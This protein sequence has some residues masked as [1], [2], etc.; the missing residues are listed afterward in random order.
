MKVLFLCGFFEKNIE[1]LILQYAKTN[2]DFA[3][4]NFQK[5]IIQGLKGGNVNYQV[6]SAPFIGSYPNASKKMFFKINRKKSFLDQTTECTYVNFN[7]VWGIRNFSRAK[8]L[9]RELKNFI[10][11]K[12]KNKLIIVYSVHT[13]FLEA[14][15]YAKKRDPRIKICLVVPDLPQYMN[16]SKKI[17]LIYRLGK[18][19]DIKRFCRLNRFVDSYMLLTEQMTEKID[20]RHKPYIVVE[21]IIDSNVFD[22]NERL[23][24]S[25]N[26]DE[27]LKYI[28]YTG[29]MNQ[30][31]GIVNL[32]E[33]F[34]KL[35]GEHYRLVLCGKGDLDQYV[36]E[37]ATEDTRIL[38]LGQV[39]A[40]TAREWMLRAD[41][42]VNPREDNEEYTK[43]SF[44][45]KDIEYL[46]TGNPV[47]AYILSGMP[48]IY[49][50]FFYCVQGEGMEKIIRQALESNN[51]DKFQN[52]IKYSNAITS[53]NIINEILKMLFNEDKNEG[54]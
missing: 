3:A 41:V 15:V 14:A 51:L 17:S 11:G 48:A 50:N 9:K 40:E 53:T 46:T 29:A 34:E 12:E 21:G 54:C 33:A 8:A 49:K 4:N 20:V 18:K 26:K 42:L 6:M 5:K 19:Y 35:S 25:L 16:L 47:V 22:E 7:N 38:V 45:S 1:K 44:P 24:Q 39:T 2:I 23:K 13:P 30:K 28:V 31:Y 37:K 27:C 52:F 36:R 32:V 43:Y 10:F